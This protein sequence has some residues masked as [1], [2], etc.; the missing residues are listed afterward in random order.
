MAS[1]VSTTWNGENFVI[2]PSWMGR[3]NPPMC[4]P[5]SL[6]ADALLLT[7]LDDFI[8]HDTVSGNPSFTFAMFQLLESV[9]KFAERFNCHLIKF[10]ELCI[11]DCVSV[12]KFTEQCI[13]RCVD[14][15]VSM[16]NLVYHTTW[17]VPPLLSEPFESVQDCLI[18]YLLLLLLWRVLFSFFFSSR[19]L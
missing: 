9:G 19:V 16:T 8:R 17:F 15:L 2:V 3:T 13:G 7:Q 18:G 10:I 12:I 14:G 4:K 1:Y 11:D 5:C 6:S